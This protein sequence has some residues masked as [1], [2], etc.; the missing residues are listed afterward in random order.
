MSIGNRGWTDDRQG[1]E[2]ARDSRL[3][4]RSAPAACCPG[5]AEM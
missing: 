1:S 5:S 2:T 4:E 3:A